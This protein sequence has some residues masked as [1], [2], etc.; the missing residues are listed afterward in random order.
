MLPLFLALWLQAAPTP[1]ADLAS[2]SGSVV[3]AATGAPLRRAQVY[4]TPGANARESRNTITDAGGRFYFPNLQPGNYYLGAEREGFVRQEYGQRAPGRPPRMLTLSPG[5]RLDD[6]NLRLQPTGVISGRIVSDDGER[7]ARVNVQ[8]IRQS[9][10]RGRKQYIPLSTTT[11]DDRGEYRIF[12]L[13]PDRYWIV[14]SSMG[15]AAAAYPPVLYPGSVDISQATPIQVTAGTEV[16]GIDFQLRTSRLATVRG[17]ILGRGNLSMQ[18]GNISLRLRDGFS[19]TPTY[20]AVFTADGGFEIRNVPPG[21]YWLQASVMS[22]GKPLLSRIPLNIGDQ[23]PEPLSIAMQPASRVSGK[24]VFENS[25]G[26]RPPIGMVL[27]LE[28]K[29]TDQG[30]V[31][32]LSENLTFLVDNLPPAEYWI[33][34]T[35]LPAGYY[36]RSASAGGQEL[37]E[38]G[39]NLNNGGNVDNLVLTVSPKSA[40]LSGTVQHEGNPYPH[41]SVVLVPE[42]SRRRQSRYFRLLVSDAA[43]KFSLQGVPPGDYKLFAWEYIPGGNF[44]DPDF[45]AR[46]EANGKSIRLA[47]SANETLTLDLI[48]D[49]GR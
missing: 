21:S 30:Q 35:P 17:K 24:V 38:D 42:G 15:N 11:T 13:P 14:A 22:D 48:P 3:N 27:M 29:D 2:L 10:T 28:G 49:D 33:N 31:S 18:N 26:S 19:A 40:R 37:I 9:V 20:G 47:E 23:D 34:V 25:D 4:L 41:A 6:I 44:E 43:G 32:Q 46:F 5:M 39:V 8:A 16:S 45:L 36:L 12:G 7:L 1:Q